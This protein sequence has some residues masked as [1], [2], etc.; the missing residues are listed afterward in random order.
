MA[1]GVRRTVGAYAHREPC[2]AS[3][4]RHVHRYS[5]QAATQERPWAQI[6]GGGRGEKTFQTLVEGKVE[7]G[8]LVVRV[9]NTDTD[10]QVGE[11]HFKSRTIFLYDFLSQGDTDKQVGEHRFKPRAV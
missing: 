8:E 7:G 3:S 1:E 10:K 11:H 2:A 9:Y 4:G 5:D 6:I